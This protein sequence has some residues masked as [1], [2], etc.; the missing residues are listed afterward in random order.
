MSQR[1]LFENEI[2]MALPKGLDDALQ[3]KGFSREKG[4]RTYQRI[5]EGCRQVIVFHFEACPRDDPSQ[6]VLIRP[7]IQIEFPELSQKA[8]E[9]ADHNRLILPAPEVVVALPLTPNLLTTPK[10]GWFATGKS[11]RRT[12]IKAGC[13]CIIAYGLPFLDEMKSAEDLIGLFEGEDARL[14]FDGRMVV[15]VAAAFLA[16]GKKH[17]ACAL[18]QSRFG[19]A[20]LAKRYRAVLENACQ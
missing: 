14:R 18:V 9:L 20:A 3:D 5:F 19:K 1:E 15:F 8:W 16:Q 2:L 17:E 4:S 13:E 6:D 12:A 7:K 10:I 11:A